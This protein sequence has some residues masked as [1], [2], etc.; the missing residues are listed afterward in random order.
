MIAMHF[1]TAKR[2]LAGNDGGGRRHAVPAWVRLLAAAAVYFIV[3]KLGLHFAFLHASTSAVSPATGLALSILLV[4]GRR[5]WPAIFLGAVFVHL[6]T[7]G[8]WLNA[9]MIGSGNTLE[10]VTGA[11]LVSRYANG[12]RAF[13]RA[14]T[15]VL[16]WFLACMV[17]TAIAAS[18]GV[19]SLCV[20]GTA[21]WRDFEPLW[22]TW[23]L[24]DAVGGFLGAALI[25]LWS[26]RTRFEWRPG[27]MLETVAVYAVVVGIAM[28]VFEGWLTNRLF[29]ILP[30]L[31]WSAFR[32]GPRTTAGAVALLTVVSTYGTLNHSGPFVMS[33]PSLN[34]ALLRLQSYLAVFA[35]TNLTVASVVEEGR[36]AAD[37]LRTAR[38]EMEARVKER[39][40]M[41]SAANEAL[42]DLAASVQGA[43]ED[44]RRRVARE[45]HDDL[46]QRLV[47]LK[48]N[49]EM[50]KPELAGGS[51]AG[52]ERVD[53][54]VEEAD[55]LIV[56]VRR[57]SYNLR[58]A[59]L[60]DFGLSKAI[61]MLCRE[62]ERVYHVSTQLAMDGGA[63]ELHDEQLDIALYRLAQGALSNVAKHAAA[64]RVVVSMSRR[65]DT[66]V[67]AVE[68]D[69]RGFDATS[70]RRRR[71]RYAGLGL[72]GMR[73]RAELLGGTLAIESTPG[74]GTRV[75]AEI[76]IPHH[77]DPGAPAA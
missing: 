57:I 15:V 27:R 36:E 34:D 6:T 17:S 41:L 45:L 14:R 22:F 77:D 43:Q 56:E 37:A 24:G 73:E 30:A 61:E 39:T 75:R 10:A 28:M 67:L 21:T 40:S 38:D 5:F 59:A 8:S 54:L 46:A 65:E 50:Y 20:T 25:L 16:F 68:D 63:V 71:D 58:P 69:G 53:A 2:Y 47:A 44:E 31:L 32:L 3:G 66:V 42:R 76:P 51:G 18:I 74:R 19:T 62:F 4:W 64:S 48:L 7:A 55:Q 13:E 33:A 52:M 9:L 60:D 11:A 26:S 72:T 29:Y 70:V 49:L 12:R 1:R 23:W 35:I